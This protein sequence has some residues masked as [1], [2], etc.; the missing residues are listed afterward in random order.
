MKVFSDAKWNRDAF[1][2]EKEVLL[3]IKE[4]GKMKHGFP[5]MISFKEDSKGRS[6]I[7]M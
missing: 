3:K 6:E 2:I 4:S 5:H 1:I 7:L